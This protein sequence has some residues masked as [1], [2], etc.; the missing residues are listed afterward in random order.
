MPCELRKEKFCKVKIGKV[1]GGCRA[2]DYV[3]RISSDGEN[4]MDEISWE[5]W[6][7]FEAGACGGV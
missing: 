1:G 7:S 6:Y 4:G 3:C 5:C 2:V